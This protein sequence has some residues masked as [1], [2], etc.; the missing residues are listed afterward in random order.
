MI[1]GTNCMKVLRICVF[2]SLKRIYA[3]SIGWYGNSLINNLMKL[4]SLFV[5]VNDNKKLVFYLRI[6]YFWSLHLTT[7]PRTASW[8]VTNKLRFVLGILLHFSFC[9]AHFCLS[10]WSAWSITKFC[11]CLRNLFKR[12]K[13]DWRI[14]RPSSM[15]DKPWLAIKL[16]VCWNR[17]NS[18]LRS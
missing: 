13:S 18:F 1:I 14:S 10:P 4:F 3:G 15:W 2:I 11:H 16:F 8:A 6:G 9:S 17:L 12:I 5:M 7:I